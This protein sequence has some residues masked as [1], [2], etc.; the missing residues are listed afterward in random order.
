MSVYRLMFLCL[1]AVT[2]GLTGPLARGLSP[3]KPAAPQIIE[4]TRTAGV[5][6]LKTGSSNRCL[7]G[8]IAWFGCWHNAVPPET[9]GLLAPGVSGQ[10]SELASDGIRRELKSSRIFRPPRLG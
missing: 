7:R 1:L 6:E 4:N 5:S 3:Q 2:L 9:A 10:P 8:A